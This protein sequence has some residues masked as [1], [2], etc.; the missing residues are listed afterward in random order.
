MHELGGVCEVPF[1]VRCAP[2]LRLPTERAD[3]HWYSSGEPAPGLKLDDRAEREVAEC[4]GLRERVSSGDP[5]LLELDTAAQ[6][7]EVRESALQFERVAPARD[8]ILIDDVVTDAS[9][10]DPTRRLTPR[11]RVLALELELTEAGAVQRLELELPD[12]R[13][14]ASRSVASAEIESD[15]APNGGRMRDASSGHVPDESR[16]RIGRT[17]PMHGGKGLRAPPNA[18][19]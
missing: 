7:E 13:L 12:D 9:A 5:F 18:R 14:G 15:Q 16:T 4:V 10:F 11:P 6:L 1:A 2:I 19:W 8:R 3:Q 17:Q